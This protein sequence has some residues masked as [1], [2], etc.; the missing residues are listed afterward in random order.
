MYRIPAFIVVVFPLL[1]F[2]VVGWTELR[3]SR[4]AGD[5][6]RRLV[7]PLLGVAALGLIWNPAAVGVVTA[8]E[9]EGL[10]YILVLV[11]SVVACSGVIV[12][13]SRRSSGIWMALG[14]LTLVFVS[15]S[16]RIHY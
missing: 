7:P 2:V 4:A 6:L 5:L 9:S 16:A 13:Y 8:E 11:A 12:T 10:S 15:L 14:G 3:A 1:A